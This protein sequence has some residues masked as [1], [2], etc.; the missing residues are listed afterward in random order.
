MKA[1]SG[2]LIV[3]EINNERTTSSGLIIGD[4]QADR[5]LKVEV[6]S[7]GKD[8]DN[9]K[10]MIKAPC[11]DGDKVYIRRPTKQGEHIDGAVL[12]FITFQDVLAVE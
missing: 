8:Y 3:K 4:S 10:R 2:R 9:G 5:F 11:K 12:Y 1:L 6:I 7:C